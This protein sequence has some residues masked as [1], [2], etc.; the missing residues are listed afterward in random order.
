[1]AWGNEVK[2]GRKQGS[3]SVLEVTWAS[4][5]A[6]VNNYSACGV[7]HLYSW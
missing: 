3:L 2:T 6:L 1:M 5:Q 4:M 7:V